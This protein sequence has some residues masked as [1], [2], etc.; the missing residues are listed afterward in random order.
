MPC[1]GSM[2]GTECRRE[3]L[4]L[5]I[6]SH[7]I[8]AASG[9]KLFAQRPDMQAAAVKGP[10]SPDP[11][12]ERVLERFEKVGLPEP[13]VTRQDRFLAVGTARPDFSKRILRMAEETAA[14]Y[15][16]FFSGL[17]L[18]ATSGK[19]RLF[20]VVLANAGQYSRFN[21]QN[22]AR[23]EG[24]HYDIDEN[25]T[26]TFDHRGRSKSSRADLERANVVTMIH[27]IAHQLSFN[28][29][30]LSRDADI[31]MMISEGLATMA[32]PSGSSALPG[33]SEVNRARI[34]VLEQLLRAK[35]A[36]WIPL[37]KLIETDEAFDAPDDAT[38]QVAYAQ[39]WLFWDSVIRQ[40]RFRE[41]L[42]PYLD[43]VN[44]QRNPAK[45]LDDFVASFG[46]VRAVEKEMAANLQ[47]I[48]ND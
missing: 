3:F 29:G 14:G 42:G 17:R 26:V 18:P 16:R 13:G 6:G 45:R 20:I 40:S 7:L 10:G 12:V 38:V 8:A 11:E 34:A 44:G 15:F 41:K 19:Q 24:G 37:E 1:R 25:W 43:R 28:T 22:K 39:S 30:L 36:R 23:N 32:E 46:S 35:R 21:G 27:E 4:K 31:P 5:T 33:F 48:S 47:S 9:E 2:S